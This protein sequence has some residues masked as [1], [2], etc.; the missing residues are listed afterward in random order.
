M[1][2][3]AGPLDLCAA[4]RQAQDQIGSVQGDGG[5]LRKAHGH[6]EPENPA[7]VSPGAS[8]RLIS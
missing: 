5:R 2:R 6:Q 3:K 8:H 4:K 7:S 1:A